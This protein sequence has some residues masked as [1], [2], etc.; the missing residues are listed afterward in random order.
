[1]VVDRDQKLMLQNDMRSRCW[2]AADAGSRR[3]SMGWFTSSGVR[4]S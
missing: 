3:G 4:C 2:K 1:M